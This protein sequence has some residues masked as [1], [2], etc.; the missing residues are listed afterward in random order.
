MRPDR[1]DCFPRRHIFSLFRCLSTVQELTIIWA[2]NWIWPVHIIIRD[3]F[4]RC[5][6]CIRWICTGTGRGL[7]MTCLVNSR[8]SLTGGTG[9]GLTTVACNNTQLFSRLR[10]R[11]G[12]KDRP[13]L[14]FRAGSFDTGDLFLSFWSTDLG[15]T[16]A[17]TA[18]GTSTGPVGW[19][20][21]AKKGVSEMRCCV[22]TGLTVETGV[23]NTL[24]RDNNASMRA[25]CSAHLSDIPDNK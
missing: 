3:L 12:I 20:A 11:A 16:G 13:C 18:T 4:I 25:N 1:M 2:G 21:G 23:E 5:S 10:T 17:S 7:F 24:S 22:S 19:V 15:F 14:C 9:R 8:R 6:F